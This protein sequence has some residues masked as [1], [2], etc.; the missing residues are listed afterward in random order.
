MSEKPFFRESNVWRL[1]GLVVLLA[2]GVFAALAP[3]TKPA[4]SNAT[5]SLTVPGICA[6]LGFLLAGYPTIKELV[7]AWINRKTPDASNQ[8]PAG[9][10]V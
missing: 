7:L 2:A 8:P 1:I 5:V 9:P 4:F 3:E 10:Q 6:A